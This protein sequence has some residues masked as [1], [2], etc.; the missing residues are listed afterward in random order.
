[1]TLEHCAE[2]LRDH[3]P[4]RFGICLLAAPEARAKLLTLYAL[5]LELARAPLAANEPMLAEMR[6]Q[7][8]IDE[9]RA[10]GTGRTTTHEL[11][12]PLAVAWGERASALAAVAEGRRRDAD[13]EPHADADAVIAYVGA[14]AVPLTLFAAEALDM[15]FD[16]AGPVSAQAEGVGLANW[17]A[18]LP[19]LQSVGLGLAS[20]DPAALATIAEAAQDALASAAARRRS[21]PRRIAP[22]LKPRTGIVDF[23]SRV[24]KGGGIEAINTSNYSEFRRRLGFGLFAFNGRWWVKPRR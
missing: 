8:W 2:A 6:L 9:L 14:T 19:A 15:P 5:N 11:L 22:V 1:M 12:A 21:V 17:L 18:A 3:D 20:P 24:A 4:D 23:L 7:W 10:L 13:H 16:A